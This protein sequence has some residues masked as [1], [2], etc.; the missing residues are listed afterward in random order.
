[1]ILTYFNIVYKE[2]IKMV[3]VKLGE[4]INKR[5][6]S[7]KRKKDRGKSGIIGKV[8]DMQ[9]LVNGDTGSEVLEVMVDKNKGTAL[10]S[11]RGLNSVKLNNIDTIGKAVNLGK[12]RG[13]SAGGINYGDMGG[14]VDRLG[15]L[16]RSVEVNRGRAEVERRQQL[17][18]NDGIM[19]VNGISA[20]S[21]LDELGV[22]VGVTIP[23]PYGLTLEVSLPY[24]I[25]SLC[26]DENE[27]RAIQG[28]LSVGQGILLNVSEVS[29]LELASIIVIVNV[30]LGVI[31]SVRDRGLVNICKELD[32]RYSIED[33]LNYLVNRLG[34][35]DSV[36]EKIPDV[37]IQ[38]MEFKDLVGLWYKIV[39]SGMIYSLRDNYRPNNYSANTGLDDMAMGILEMFNR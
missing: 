7:I 35:I 18:R 36:R 15:D 9:R 5:I 14:S 27:L 33:N 3:L 38:Y 12:E 28:L 16:R 34:I 17:V 4:A 22:P 26:R 32:P 2:C 6:K 39:N 10:S 11:F 21:I 20:Q 30:R 19:G 24:N 8:N 25:Q 37:K 29:L 31:I 23:L 13:L 1:M